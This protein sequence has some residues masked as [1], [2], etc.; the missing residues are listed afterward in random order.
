MGCA[1]DSCPNGDRLRQLHNSFLWVEK[2]GCIREYIYEIYLLSTLGEKTAH[3]N[4]FMWDMKRVR[5]SFVYI[6]F[7]NVLKCSFR[8]VRISVVLSHPQTRSGSTE[9]TKKFLFGGADACI[10][11]TRSKEEM[12]GKS[13]WYFPRWRQDCVDFG[14]CLGLFFSCAHWFFF[15]KLRTDGHAS[16]TSG[17]AF[18]KHQVGK[19]KRYR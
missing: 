8:N 10:F 6:I 16:R 12:E 11:W 17:E 13:F 1:C 5:I 2:K 18:S 9:C 15:L 7:V 4:F 19:K 3:L 14:L